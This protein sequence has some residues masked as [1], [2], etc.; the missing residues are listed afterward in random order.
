M[1]YCCI[2]SILT[3]ILCN[4]RSLHLCHLR[5]EQLQPYKQKWHHLKALFDQPRKL[6]HDQA[7]KLTLRDYCNIVRVSVHMS[8][9]VVPI[10]LRYIHC[11]GCHI[12]DEL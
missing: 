3:Y 6:T 1:H 5:L 9:I 10:N 2:K 7:Q 11:I 4:R 8:Y 12:G